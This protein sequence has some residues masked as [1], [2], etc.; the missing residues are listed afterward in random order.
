MEHIIITPVYNES[1]Y[2]RNYLDSII[3]QTHRPFQLIMV[4]DNSTDESAQI[5]KKYAKKHEWI[6]Y[7]YHSSENKK[8]QGKKVIQAFNFG[9]NYCDLLEIDIISK[10]D[11]DLQFPPNY[12]E[13]IMAAFK[14]NSRLG[15][16]GG[17]IEEERDSTWTRI[18]QAEYHI[19]GALK[20]YRK[21]CFFEMGGIMPILG[22]DG[23]D[24]MKALYFNWETHI[25]ELGVKHFRPAAKDYNKT[26]LNYKLG[27]ANYEN[28]G[29][30][31]LAFV[32]ALVKS[33]QK[34]YFRTGISYFKG[35]LTAKNMKI[36]KNVDPE[37]AKFIN[38]FHLKRLLT[39]KR[40]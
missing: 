8:S 28:G 3:K 14:F 2:L 13:E 17:I 38:D 22:W 37:L 39:L 7:V 4:D 27:F 6:K 32:R 25:I 40:Y 5:I 15:I 29:N 19:R 21:E 12:F 1:K 20:S 36:N 9:L 34:P 33:K 18:P 31:F 26:D 23:L 35:Y 30:L 24:E 16:A 10:I 11:A